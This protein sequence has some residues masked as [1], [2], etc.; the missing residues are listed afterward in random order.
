MAQWV[1]RFAVVAV[2]DRQERGVVGRRKIFIGGPGGRQVIED[3]VL[4]VPVAE[5]ADGIIGC[6]G[7]IVNASAHGEIAHDVVLGRPAAAA[8]DL[9][10]VEK[11][12]WVVGRRIVD[13]GDARPRRRLAGDGDVR[14]V[15]REIGRQ[16]DRSADVED[17]GS[18]AG[19][20]GADGV[21]QRPRSVRVGE[22]GDVID[23]AIASADGI[24]SET[25]RSRKR[26]NR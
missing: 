25:L 12:A 19:R 21:A 14:L 3:D 16:D 23:V 1:E 15:E 18:S 26:W 20:R 4:R 10:L 5:H 9:E 24:G 13:Q 6:G 22:A 8:G 2:L 7:G 17:D 11:A